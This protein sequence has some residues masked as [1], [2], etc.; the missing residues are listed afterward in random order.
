MAVWWLFVA[1]ILFN[2]AADP[3]YRANI[4]IVLHLM[5]IVPQS[6]LARD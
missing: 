5:G 4:L 1:R 2:V 3:I 6:W